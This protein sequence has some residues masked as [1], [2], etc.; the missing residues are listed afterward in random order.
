MVSCNLIATE[1]G[2]QVRY[3][4]KA[5]DVATEHGRYGLSCMQK[6]R[7]ALVVLSLYGMLECQLCC[8][9]LLLL[10]KAHMACF[11]CC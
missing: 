6:L 11:V 1:N 9:L 10:N 4:Q 2:R 8:E 5:V 3:M 7:S